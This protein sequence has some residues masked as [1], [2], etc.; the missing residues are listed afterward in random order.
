[1]IGKS[2]REAREVRGWSRKDTARELGVATS[3]YDAYEGCGKVPADDVLGRMVEKMP[4]LRERVA[5]VRKQ[6]RPRNA[7]FTRRSKGP[8]RR[9]NRS[10]STRSGSPLRGRGGGSEEPCG[11]RMG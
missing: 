4:E 2:L 9:G 6:Y 1:M 7:A 11:T 5:A 10:A 3:T 8:R